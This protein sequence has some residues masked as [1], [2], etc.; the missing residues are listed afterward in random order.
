MCMQGKHM[1]V[2]VHSHGR[3]KSIWYGKGTLISPA[4]SK[5]TKSECFFK[6]CRT[7]SSLK[8]LFHNFHV[9]SWYCYSC[10]KLVLPEI[11]R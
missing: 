10:L 11:E 5:E 2:Y 3:V 7:N 4:E 8:L 1:Y 9:K 6:A